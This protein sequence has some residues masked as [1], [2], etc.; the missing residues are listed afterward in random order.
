MP[1]RIVPSLV[2][3]NVGNLS[4]ETALFIVA[5]CAIVYVLLLVLL[6]VAGKREVGQMTPFDLVVLLLISNAVQNAMTGP[7][8]SVGGGIVAAVTLIGISPPIPLASV[9]AAK[10]YE[11]SSTELPPFSFATARSSTRICERRG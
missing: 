7:D 6:R 11:G 4:L 10:S 3:T 1:F 9:S 8:T 2:L 5:R